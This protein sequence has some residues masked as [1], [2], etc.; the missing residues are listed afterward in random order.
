MERPKSHH[1]IVLPERKNSE[2]LLPDFFETYIPMKRTI[3]K[4]PKMRI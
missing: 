2:E 4:N 3:A 1:G